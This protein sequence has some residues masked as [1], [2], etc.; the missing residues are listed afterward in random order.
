MIYQEV[1]E[2]VKTCPRCQAHWDA[3]APGLI[4]AFASVGIEHGKSSHEMAVEYFG[5]Y[6]K[7]SHVFN[8]PPIVTRKM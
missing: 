5:I 8:F 1:P 4:H 3:E 6:H 7:K 2:I